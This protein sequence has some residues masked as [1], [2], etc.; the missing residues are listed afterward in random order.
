M[1]WRRLCLGCIDRNSNLGF[2]KWY[3]G[4]QFPPHPHHHHHHPA[5][6]PPRPLPP[7][8]Q[9]KSCKRHDYSGMSLCRFRY[10]WSSWTIILPVVMYGCETW[11]VT[12]REERRLRVFENRAL[13]RIFGSKIVEVTGKWRRLYRVSQEECA[14]LRKG[15]P[16]VKVYRYNPKH[17]YPKL[18]GYGDNGQRNLGASCGSKYCNLHSW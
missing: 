4:R 3:Q 17:L 16:Y 12:L 1:S 5:P 18:N 11:S 6:T 10:V 8:L 14:R 2:W 9:K 13:R 7:P 15:V